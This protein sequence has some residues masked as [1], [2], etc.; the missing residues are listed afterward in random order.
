MKDINID[1][2]ML[3]CPDWPPDDPRGTFIATALAGEAGELLNM[4]KKEWRG[5]W[6]YHH[7]NLVD[8]LGDVAAYALMLA[9]HLKVDLIQEGERRLLAFEQ[10]PE[11]PELLRKAK[12]RATK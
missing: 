1:D 9:R 8:E 2:H 10:R 6:T 7:S 3:I 5:G 11:Y 12:E 4:F